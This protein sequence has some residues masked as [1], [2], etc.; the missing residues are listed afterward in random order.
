M[1]RDG[2][3]LAC[4]AHIFVTP[5]S[6]KTYVG[7]LTGICVTSR[8]NGACPIRI[9]TLLLGLRVLHSVATMPTALGGASTSLITIV[10]ASNERSL[11]G[12]RAAQFVEMQHRPAWLR[13]DELSWHGGDAGSDWTYF[14]ATNETARHLAEKLIAV[15]L[16]DWK[17]SLEVPSG[18]VVASLEGFH[19]LRLA[20]TDIRALAEGRQEVD[21]TPPPDGIVF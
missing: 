2:E 16:F 1:I 8:L 13:F 21:W 11:R 7:E 5:E 17:I 19:E 10:K 3:I 9:H 6:A 12:I 14:Y 18:S 15:G 4:S 20:E